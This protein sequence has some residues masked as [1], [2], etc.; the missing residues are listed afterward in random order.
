MPLVGSNRYVAVVDALQLSMPL[1][2]HVAGVGV[3]HHLGV[4]DFFFLRRV[5]GG[6]L[7]IKCGWDGQLAMPNNS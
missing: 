2:A 4:L 1:F 6:F 7:S 5:Q 3:Q